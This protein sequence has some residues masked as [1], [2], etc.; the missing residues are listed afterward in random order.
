MERAPTGARSAFVHA[1]FT[2]PRARAA[3]RP[4][5]P[6]SSRAIPPGESSLSPPRMK[7][8]SLLH[9]A[10]LGACSAAAIL[11]CQEPVHRA[12][13]AEA[14]GPAM[15]ATGAAAQAVAQA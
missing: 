3:T 9:L 1:M 13:A 4:P 5:A 6:W 11:A 14:A 12:P 2:Y 8:P 10:L 7:R 15:V